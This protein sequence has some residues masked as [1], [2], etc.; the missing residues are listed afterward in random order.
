M[1]G[2]EALGPGLRVRSEGACQGLCTSVS[3]NGSWLPP[4]VL[5][6]PSRGRGGSQWPNQEAE[7]VFR[8]TQDL[9]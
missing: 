3:H 9:M 1:A 5:L 7:K 2:L 6:S 8:N 4:W